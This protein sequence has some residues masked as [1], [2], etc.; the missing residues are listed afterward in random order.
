MRDCAQTYISLDHLTAL[1]SN[2]GDKAK[3]VHLP[4]SDHHVQHGIN[5]NEGTSPP[6]ARAD[7]Q[8]YDM[9]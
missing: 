4:L 1:R 5:H 2:P 9:L 8:K 6:H 3:Y 7:R